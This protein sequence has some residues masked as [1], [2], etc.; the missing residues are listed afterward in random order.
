MT[1]K[2]E[3]FADYLTQQGYCFI[4]MPAGVRLQNIHTQATHLENLLYPLYARWSGEGSFNPASMSELYRRMPLITNTVFD[5]V[6]PQGIVRDTVNTYRTFTPDAPAASD[7]SLWLEYLARAFPNDVDRTAVCSWLAHIFQRPEQR[8]TWHLVIPSD[9]GTGKGFLFHSILSPLLA[10][11]T[12]HYSSYGQLTEKHNESLSDNLI[13]LFDDPPQ[14][15]KRVAESLKSIQTEPYVDIR[16]LYETARKVRTYT[17]FM[18]FSNN[19]HPIDVEENDRRH[20]VTNRMEHHT[21]R[22]ETAA[23]IATLSDWLKAGGLEA[24][25]GWFMAY[26]LTHFNPYAPP[27][28]EALERLKEASI[29]PCHHQATEFTEK[30]QVFSF[31]LFQQECS[32]LEST[33]S[34]TEW[35]KSNGYTSGRI[36][37]N[38]PYKDVKNAPKGALWYPVSVDK[39]EAC[40]WYLEN[41][42]RLDGSA[43]SA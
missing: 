3:R 21:D 34:A 20:Y 19:D 24:I 7:L 16:P 33:R 39:T 6:A 30:R 43:G 10:H 2:T 5:P 40:R 27:H 35:L 18:T 13:V 8:P 1:T 31:E 36:F 32:L 4:S 38:G 12:K 25:H 9:T 26:D 41:I 37:K 28:S 23:F 14:A 17:R 29:S 42:L 11:Q 15:T 22:A